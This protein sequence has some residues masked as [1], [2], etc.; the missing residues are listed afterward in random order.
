MKGFFLK[1]LVISAIFVA[2]FSR[3]LPPRVLAIDFGV[4]FPNLPTIQAEVLAFPHWQLG[5]GYGSFWVLPP[6]PYYVPSQSILFSDGNTYQV[7]PVINISFDVLQ[8]FVRWFPTE[9]NFYLQLNFATLRI[10]MPYK[11]DVTDVSSGTTIPSSVMGNITIYQTMPTFSL[12]HIFSGKAYFFNVSLGFTFLWLTYTTSSMLLL[13][14][15]LFG[16]AGS[17]DSQ[18]ATMNAN[19]QTQV[20]AALAPY[21]TYYFCLPSIAFSFGIFL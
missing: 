14:E 3:G 18:V 9:R 19:L 12:G 21:K 4:G 16:G 20:N 1:L 15:A 17:N 10:L 11:S 6:I 8:P 2:N 13:N 5:F 7:S